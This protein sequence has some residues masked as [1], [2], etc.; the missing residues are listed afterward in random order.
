MKK[1]KKGDTLYYLGR[2]RCTVLDNTLKPGDGNISEAVLF[3]QSAQ[4][5][6]IIVPVAFQEKFVSE[7]QIPFYK[8][9]PLTQDSGRIAQ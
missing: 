9:W 4:G 8:K 7:A 1:Y 6:S 3:L 2:T 5:S